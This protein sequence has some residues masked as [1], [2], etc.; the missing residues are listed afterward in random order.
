MTWEDLNKLTRWMCGFQYFCRCG[1]GKEKFRSCFKVEKLIEL[2]LDFFLERKKMGMYLTLGWKSGD[3]GRWWWSS[4]AHEGHWR[5]GGET[6]GVDPTGNQLWKILMP[7]NWILKKKSFK[8]QFLKN[9][10]NAVIWFRTVFDTWN[11][12]W[13]NL[14]Y[15]E[16]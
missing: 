12:N 6:V 10:W 4:A 9:S 16:L 1:R 7:F 3:Q 5:G 14:I 13:I 11:L 15:T 2:N 8:F